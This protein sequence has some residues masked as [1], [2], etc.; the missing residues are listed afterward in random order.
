MS[1]RAGREFLSIPGPTVI[2]D[3]V[4]PMQRP[5]SISIPG[6]CAHRRLSRTFP[7]MF[8]TRGRLHHA[9]NGHGAGSCAT[10]ALADTKLVLSS[11]AIGWARLRGGHRRGGGGAPGDFAGSARRHR[12]PL[13]TPAR[14]RRRVAQI[15]T[16]SR[17]FAIADL[18]G[19]PR[20]RSRRALMVD[21]SPRRAVRLEMD[22]W[23]VTSRCPASQKG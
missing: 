20:G 2:P 3:A 23:G 5:A 12:G 6:R 4:S 22:D 7:K 15:D 10:N 18:S 19:D 21:G 14:S 11:A 9:A 8:R 13:R 17:R 16:A 1:V